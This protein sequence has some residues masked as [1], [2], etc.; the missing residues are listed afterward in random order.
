MTGSG[1]FLKWL[2]VSQPNEVCVYHVGDLA[3]DR[4]KGRSRGTATP[5]EVEQGKDANNLANAA[6]TAYKHGDVVLSQRKLGP[7][8]YEYRATRT[9]RD[10]AI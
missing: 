2:M 4:A 6:W 3:Q 10:R 7:N 5:Q 8:N 9:K 1:N